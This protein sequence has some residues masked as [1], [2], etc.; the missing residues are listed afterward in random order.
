MPKNLKKLI[1][2]AGLLAGLTVC[3][4]EWVTLAWDPSPS[5]GVVAYHIHGGT[6]AACAVFVT[7]A[8]LSCTQ[9]VAVPFPGR[10]FF[11]ATAVDAQGRESQPS[12]VVH[13]DVNPEPP[14][15]HGE[16]WLRLTPVL[17]RSTNG[18]DWSEFQGLA[19]WVP[20][21]NRTEWFRPVRLEG[22][23]VVRAAP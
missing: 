8:N 5:P 17:Q 19:T 21:T 15:L 22:E 4:A 14:V 12:N 10:W 13:W 16:P 1:G 23:R 7:N 2:L 20:A 6:N 11:V 3:G 18:V 9:T